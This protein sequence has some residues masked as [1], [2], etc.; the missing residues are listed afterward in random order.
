MWKTII[1]LWKKNGFCYKKTFRVSGF[2]EKIVVDI[3]VENL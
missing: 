3:V 2:F 1:F